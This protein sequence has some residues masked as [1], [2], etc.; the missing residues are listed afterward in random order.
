MGR[1]AGIGEA[2]QGKKTPVFEAPNTYR[3]KIADVKYI[4]A[5]DKHE[6]YI[7]ETEILESDSPNLL[8]GTKASQVMR[9]TDTYGYGLRDA[10][11]FNAAVLGVDP[12]GFADFDGKS[13]DEYWDD[14]A[15]QS[16]SDEE[17][18]EE[19]PYAGLE[20]QLRTTLKPKAESSGHVTLHHWSA[21]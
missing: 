21:L 13:E 17:T 5:R 1:F 12:D 15:E 10:R 6:Y 3:V 2:H 8:P 7:V 19:S 9:I 11:A 14:I 20:M 4:T 16:L 18:G